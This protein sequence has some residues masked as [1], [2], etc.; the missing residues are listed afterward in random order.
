MAYLVLDTAATDALVLDP[1]SSDALVLGFAEVVWFVPPAPPRA[2]QVRR[3]MRPGVWY[4][5]APLVPLYPPIPVPQSGIREPFPVI[6]RRYAPRSVVVEP[7]LSTPGVVEFVLPD[8]CQAPRWALDRAPAWLTSVQIVSP[9]IPAPDAPCSCPA[10]AVL[11]GGSLMAVLVQGDDD[12][13]F[14][15]STL[16]ASLVSTSLLGAVLVQVCHCDAS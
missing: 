11:V 10:G 13:P 4:V 1:T 3:E 9:L 5:E 7:P 15:R 12:D 16:S 6:A 8:S 2:P 14:A